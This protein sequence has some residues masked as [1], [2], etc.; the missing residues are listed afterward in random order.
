MNIPILENIPLD[1]IRFLLVV[2]F[3]LLIGLEQRRN[4]INVAPETVFGTDR[5]F[6][7]IGILGFIL[8]IISPQ[9]L[10]PFIIGGVAIGGLLGIYYIKKIE[11][12]QKFG[13]TG[14]VTALIT[15]SLAPLIYTQHR[16]LI[17]LVMVCVLVISEIKETL[18][19]LSKKFDSTEFIT[20]AKFLVL[21]GIILPLLPDAP[22]SAAI[23]ISPY[24]FWLAIVVVSAISYIS[25]LL[26][27]FIFPDK[28]IL[29]TGLLG[30]LYSSTATVVIL[31]RKSK[32]N[33]EGNRVIAAMFLALTMMYLRIFI[34]A[35]FFNMA[36]AMKLLPY[37]IVFIILSSLIAAYFTL[38]KKA[39]SDIVAEAVPADVHQNPLEFKTALLFG[40]LFI[41]FALITGF[42]V[43]NYGA[44]GTKMLALVVGVT[45]INPFII[46]LFQGKWNLDATVITIAVL[47]AITSNILFQMIYAVFL[48]N[49]TLKK[50]IILG[51][52]ILIVAG[53]VAVLI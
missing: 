33:V 8:Y 2:A 28:G 21:V 32:E 13:M 30:G 42:V 45:D 52:S 43:A 46:N 39:T 44:Y 1:V 7:L 17:L 35:A 19:N 50:G 23:N 38:V 11:V 6:T 26:R 47:N 37:F 29:L 41:L 14:L 4:L 15:Y 31:A 16:W 27:K 34:F 9:N 5:T 36:V 40:V 18:L 10:L 48:S 53:I 49:K 24:K 25:Y 51:F 22:I 20:L 12:Q 3:S